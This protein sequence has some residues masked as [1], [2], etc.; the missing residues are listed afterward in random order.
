G[1]KRIAQRQQVDASG[2]PQAF[3]GRGG[4]GQQNKRVGKRI[5]L[6]QLVALVG[7]IWIRGDVIIAQGDMVANPDRL[8][9]KLLDCARSRRQIESRKLGNES[10]K[11]HD[12]SL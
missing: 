10:S 12:P 5:A 7:R 8:E 11:F 3:G 9:T 2:K 6:R 1:G 4:V